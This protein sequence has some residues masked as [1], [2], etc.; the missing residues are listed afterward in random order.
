MRQAG[1]VLALLAIAAS[2]GSAQS[3]SGFSGKWKLNPSRSEIRNLPTPPAPFLNVEE[4]GAGLTVSAAS[5]ET[6]PFSTAKYP[7]NGVEATSTVAGSTMKTLTKW[8]GSAL[9]VN[10][11]V[12]GP[13]NY[14]IMERW[15][16]SR[17]G[18]TLTIRRTII[19]LSGES[20]SLLVYENGSAPVKS[21]EPESMPS[22]QRATPAGPPAPVVPE[23]YVIES[24]TRILLRVVNSVDTKHTAPGDKVYLSTVVPVFINRRLIIPQGSS[25]IGTVT[26][27]KDAGRVKGRSALTVR[28]DSLTLPNGVTR[29]LRSRPSSAD[30]RGDLDR[31]EGRIKGEGNKSGDARKV[32]TTTAAGAT[33]GGIAAGGAGAGIGAAAGAVAGLAGVFGS[34]GPQV[35]LPAGSTMELTL[36]RDLHFTPS[37]LQ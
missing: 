3:N 19:R 25:V 34:R 8:E 1:F 6:G 14:T 4:S 18:S 33:I 21:S 7:L 30:G 31:A 20:E 9:L 37:D 28:F 11:V 15:K 16:T 32:G 29:D 5:Q 35:A 10:T 36:D 12:S 26:E 22:L 17:D 2:P 24:G 13:Q 27:S 23:E